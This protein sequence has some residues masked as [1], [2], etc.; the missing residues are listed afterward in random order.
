MKKGTARRRVVA[1]PDGTILNRYWDDLDTPRD[2][3]YAEDT[4]LARTSDRPAPQLYREL[5]AAAESGWDF[6]S[7]WFA[8]GRTLA[9]IQTTAIVPV[10]LN[11][12]LFG[13]ERAI[14]AAC[15]AQHDVRCA[16]QMTRRAALRRAAMDRFLWIA[17][18]TLTS[19]M[20][21]PSACARRGSRPRC[22]I[23]CSL[24]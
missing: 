13:L 3:S 15:K 22:S 10:D 16:Q 5:R 17:P 1:M 18:A 4:A 9:S 7:R 12:L 24:A 19:I 23:R 20:C 2:E 6:S 14:G 11:S 21:G 8:D